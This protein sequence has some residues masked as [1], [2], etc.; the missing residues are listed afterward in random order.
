MEA[1]NPYLKSMPD[2]TR[3]EYLNDQAKLLFSIQKKD[4]AVI[5][6]RLLYFIA[7]K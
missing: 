7:K 3:E 6:R 1:V 4:S 5:S 2:E